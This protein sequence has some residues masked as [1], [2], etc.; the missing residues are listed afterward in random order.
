M[1]LIIYTKP[2]HMDTKKNIFEG[3]INSFTHS[4]HLKSSYNQ[5]VSNLAPEENQFF[6]QDRGHKN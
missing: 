1:K 6:Q 4:V 3:P 2:I 5:D